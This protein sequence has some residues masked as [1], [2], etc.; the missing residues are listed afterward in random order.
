MLLDVGGA[1]SRTTGLVVSEGDLTR[2][3]NVSVIKHN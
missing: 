2:F 3:D 1:Y